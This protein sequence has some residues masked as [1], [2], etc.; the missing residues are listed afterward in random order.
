MQLYHASNRPPYKFKPSNK[1]LFFVADFDFC[2][3]F[4][5]AFRN[6]KEVFYYQ[7]DLHHVNFFDY[8]IEEHLAQLEPLIDAHKLRRIKDID[9]NYVFLEMPDVVAAIK[10]LGFEGHIADEYGITYCIYAAA[11]KVQSCEIFKSEIYES[12]ED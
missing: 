12:D 3:S 4:A 1:K 6:T 8:R 5:E 11:D 9:R 7:I 10:S 2:E